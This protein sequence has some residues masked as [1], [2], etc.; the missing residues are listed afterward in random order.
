MVEN[1]PTEIVQSVSP[2]EASI[3]LQDHFRCVAR[4]LRQKDWATQDDLV[5]ECRSQ[6]SDA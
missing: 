6:W 5:Q 2:A 3:A 1:A 4:R